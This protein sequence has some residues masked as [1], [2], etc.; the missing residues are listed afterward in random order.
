MTTWPADEL[1]RI[2]TADEL[3]LA[4]LRGDGTLRKP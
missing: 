2:E 3:E 4:T 1:A